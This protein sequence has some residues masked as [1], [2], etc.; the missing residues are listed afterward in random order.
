MG[1]LRAGY[2]WMSL[3]KHYSILN[4]KALVLIVGAPG[5]IVSS[6]PDNLYTV[7]IQDLKSNHGVP[8]LGTKFKLQICSLTEDKACLLWQTHLA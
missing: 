3:V 7:H 8:F 1:H 4:L 5:T 6:S 2:S